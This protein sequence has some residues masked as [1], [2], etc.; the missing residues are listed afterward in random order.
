MCTTSNTSTH[1]G[2]ISR[3]GSRLEDGQAHSIDHEQWTRRAFLRTLGFGAAASTF[4]MGG[5]PI[6]AIGSSAMLAPLLGTE[7][8]RI[9]VLIQLDGGNDGL[10]TVVP[11]TNDTYYRLRPNLA[12]PQD[13]TF[14][15]SDNLGMHVALNNWQPHYDSGNLAVVQGVGYANPNLSH[16]R[17][18]D[19]WMSASDANT[20]DRTGWSGRFLEQTNPN[21]FN[22]PPVDPLAVQLGGSSFMFSGREY[23]MGMTISSNE[24]FKRIEDQ[25]QVFSMDGIP[26]TTFG[27]EM[28][29]VRQIVNN[30]FRYASSIQRAS[31]NAS[32]AA[33]YPD[34]QLSE[35][36]SNVARLIKGGLNTRIYLVS[37]GGFD[38]HAYQMY[39]H[40]YLLGHLGQ[41]VDAFM[42]DLGAT[43][44]QD[45][46]LT[47]TFSE[48][49][50]TMWENG[51]Y[52]T[53]HSTAA[54]MFLM[55]SAVNGGLFGSMQDLEN[56]DENGD[57]Y[58]TVDFRSVYASVLKDWFCLDEA[59]LQTVMGGSFETMNLIGGSNPVSV[60]RET[61]VASF[62][63]DGNYPNPFRGQTRI[64]LNLSRSTHVNLDVYDLQGRKVQEVLD[65]SLSQGRHEIP[66]NR[67][68][69][70]SGT[71]LYK[72]RGE[73]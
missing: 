41:A 13:Q 69:L 44:M 56:T 25:G 38:T 57:P 73:N 16:F 70:P 62:A 49:G 26:Q 19:I 10:N 18:T 33:D 23:D 48:F 46:V 52:G 51:S 21:F 20:F 37:L 54:P 32:N 65:R 35:N 66:F 11:I 36:L 68:T 67:G 27:E 63:L 60:D 64:L 40:E 43:G 12:V 24:L 45:Q 17:S 50:R 42:Q 59:A 7:T 55:G 2:S 3:K 5:T 61:P 31:E 14:R 39:E 6:N 9:L 72:V 8:D 30:S 4:M 53:D 22:E 28:R 29:F 71:Y 15:L 58:N 1:S 34:G 47:I